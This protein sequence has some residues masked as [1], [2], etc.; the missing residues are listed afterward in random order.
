MMVLTEGRTLEF[1]ALPSKY[2]KIG[3]IEAGNYTIWAPVPV[4]VFYDPDPKSQA[5]NIFDDMDTEEVDG[6]KRFKW[7]RMGNLYVKS[8]TEGLAFCKL[9]RHEDDDQGMH[10]R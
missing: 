7:G 4:L 1:Y 6:E 3:A 8:L 5:R 9:K 10:L 2:E